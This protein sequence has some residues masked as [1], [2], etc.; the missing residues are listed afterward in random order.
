MGEAAPLVCGS[1][2]VN[3]TRRTWP[4]YQTRLAV[5]S[6]PRIALSLAALLPPLA[7]LVP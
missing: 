4:L 3:I 5:L 1:W 7:G 2:A 6:A